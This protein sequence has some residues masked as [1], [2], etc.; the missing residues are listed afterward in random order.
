MTSQG[1]KSMGRQA[2][3]IDVDAPCGLQGHR[4]K[5]RCTKS[6]VITCKFPWQKCSFRKENPER[7]DCTMN[8]LIRN[9]PK[10]VEKMRKERRDSMTGAMMS[11]IGFQLDI[12]NKKGVVEG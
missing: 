7:K 10:Q 9:I 3:Y 8:E 1:E 11:Y 6:G 4:V 5:I 12:L 2:D